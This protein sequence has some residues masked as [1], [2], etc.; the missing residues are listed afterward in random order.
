MRW[1]RWTRH[2]A[3]RQADANSGR[4]PRVVGAA[5]TNPDNNPA[6]GTTLFVID[7]GLDLGAVQDPPNAG[8]LNTFAS[9][10]ADV[11]DVLS[12]DISATQILIAVAPNTSSASAAVRRRQQCATESRNDWQRGEHSRPRDFAGTV[13]ASGRLL[14]GALSRPA[15]FAAVGGPRTALGRTA[16]AL[17]PR[18]ARSHDSRGSA[19]LATPRPSVAARGARRAFRS[20]EAARE[21]PGRSRA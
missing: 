21:P 17:P 1:R 2:S 14:R 16:S 6:T 5:Y 12:F 18:A 20:G 11:G 3:T 19:A 10:G 8:V 9:F 15:G 13:E 4:Q 7:A